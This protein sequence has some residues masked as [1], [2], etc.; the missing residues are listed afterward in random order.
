MAIDL[1][2]G[3]DVNGRK[4]V[5]SGNRF[6]PLFFQKQLKTFKITSE[7][8][9]YFKKLTQNDHPKYSVKFEGVEKIS[10]DCTDFEGFVPSQGGWDVENTTADLLDQFLA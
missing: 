5:F 10:K 1:Y 4:K 3:A 8:E 9:I 2:D 6:F 7:R